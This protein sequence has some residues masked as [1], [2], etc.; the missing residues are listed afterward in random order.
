MIIP[1]TE[2]IHES[3]YVK[4]LKLIWHMCPKKK[5]KKKKKNYNIYFVG[6]CID[7]DLIGRFS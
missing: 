7:V 1:I 2:N 6:F 5:K 4:A 3:S